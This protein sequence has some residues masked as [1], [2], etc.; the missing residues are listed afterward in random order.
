MREEEVL[1]HPLP[2]IPFALSPPRLR[3][4]R[5]SR[6]AWTGSV[7]PSA[8][9]LL[10]APQTQ[11]PTLSSGGGGGER[12][13]TAAAA[14][15]T[16]RDLTALRQLWGINARR[17]SIEWA[18]LTFRSTVQHS[19][20]RFLFC[21]RWVLLLLSCVSPPVRGYPSGETSLLCLV[22]GPVFHQSFDRFSMKRR[23]RGPFVP[24]LL[25]Q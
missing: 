20:L 15:L 18:F 13:G 8:R 1:R 12:R 5:G 19:R 24:A 21:L 3:P 14:A 23:R 4:G 6:T 11:W 10:P 9:F 25:V 2:H 22:L 16:S 17:L 7:L